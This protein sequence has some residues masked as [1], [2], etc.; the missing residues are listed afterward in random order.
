MILKNGY[1]ISYQPQAFYTDSK[2]NYKD[3]YFK[4]EGDAARYVSSIVDYIT[5]P[6]DSWRDNVELNKQQWDKQAK[7]QGTNIRQMCYPIAY[8]FVK[9]YE[10]FVSEYLSPLV[11]QNTDFLAREAEADRQAQIAHQQHEKEMARQRELEAEATYKADKEREA[12]LV[13]EREAKKL[14][15][16]QRHAARLAAAVSRWEHLAPPSV[17]RQ[18]LY[19]PDGLLTEQLWEMAIFL[20][21]L[22]SK[23]SI[24]LSR[25]SK[26]LVIRNS[27]SG[28]NFKWTFEK[29]NTG[30]TD[31]YLLTAWQIG[32]DTIR[33]EDRAYGHLLAL[34][35]AP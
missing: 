14:E 17:L 25:D 24:S 8:P 9:D 13:R 27:R 29:V 10:Q 35:F 3:S 22:N 15:Q 16:A 26:T 2:Q 7:Y 1:D 12:Q 21:R 23:P 6:I 34:Y 5:N 30:I 19:Y 31:I 32:F 33:P 18:H 11:A 20:D 4:C 28:E